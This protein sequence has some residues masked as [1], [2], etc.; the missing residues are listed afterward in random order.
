MTALQVASSLANIDLVQILLAAGADVNAPPATHFSKH[1]YEMNALE[2]AASHSEGVQG[3]KVLLE[4]GAD[5]NAGANSEGPSALVCAL[6]QQHVTLVHRLINAG[7][8]FNAGANSGRW[9][10]YPSTALAAVIHWGR[11]SIIHYLL[12]AGADVNNQSARRTGKT[13]LRAAVVKNDIELV[14]YLLDIGA[15]AN[16]SGAL[17]ATVEGIVNLELVRLLLSYITSHGERE[18][19]DVLHFKQ[20]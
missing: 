2:A 15:D 14:Q 11:Y 5:V 4:H 10:G 18:S 19:I 17:F 16:D 9:G 13:A 12:Q 8:D 7:A 6:K 20:Q 3:A 1:I